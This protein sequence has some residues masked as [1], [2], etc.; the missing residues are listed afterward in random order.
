MNKVK[1]KYFAIGFLAIVA[2]AFAISVSFESK[3]G[4]CPITP[5]VESG[6]ADNTA[7]NPK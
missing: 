2:I 4:T 5:S 7:A 6:Y 1:N 3:E